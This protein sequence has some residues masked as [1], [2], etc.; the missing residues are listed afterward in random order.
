M[1][2]AIALQS[3]T[4]RL[5]L[6]SGTGVILLQSDPGPGRPNVGR[7]TQFRS[8]LQITGRLYGSVA[9]RGGGGHTIVI[10]Q[11]N[12]T[13]A[14]Q[15]LTR[16]KTKTPTPAVEAELAQAL[17]ARKTRT[18]GPGIETDLAPALGRHKRRTLGPVTETDQAPAVSSGK[19]RTLGPAIEADL[20]QSLTRAGGRVVPITPATETD[21]AQPITV[22]PYRRLLS[23][24]METDQAQALTARKTKALGHASETDTAQSLVRRKTRTLGHAVE[25]DTARPLTAGKRKTLGVAVETETASALT[26]RKR[27]V[28]YQSGVTYG[29]LYTYQPLSAG[30]INRSISP[31]IETDVASP[32]RRDKLATLGPAG[33]TDQAQAIVT[34][35]R[36]L[37]NPAI[38]I[39]I[40]QGFGRAKRRTLSTAVETDQSGPIS[41]LIQVELHPAFET[42][43]ALPV[44]RQSITCRVSIRY[45]SGA[46]YGGLLTY[47]NRSR[48]SLTSLIGF[49]ELDVFG[50]LSI[51]ITHADPAGFVIGAITP[52]IELGAR[53]PRSRPL[54]TPTT[55]LATIDRSTTRSVLVELVHSGA[56]NCVVQ[57]IRLEW[58]QRSRRRPAA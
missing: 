6:Q 2:N 39:E 47:Q 56:T 18:L 52:L 9:G 55:F 21:A 8:S 11:A 45:Q 28:T 50:T 17:V 30:G 57:D 24:A 35:I 26:P 31:A 43:L 53:S 15:A 7:L 42:S 48:G 25:S 40:V 23:Q 19:R 38:E 3:G 1:G 44:R 12:E 36:R 37:L 10:D 4:G 16:G 54:A 14:A 41:R 51:E 33:E 46:T 58:M 49:V 22:N 20:A 29:G 32:L 27:R 34:P 13:D 5:A